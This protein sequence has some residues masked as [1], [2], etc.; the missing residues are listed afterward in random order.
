MT[1]ELNHS[2][3]ALPEH[4]ALKRK[5]GGDVEVWNDFVTGEHPHITLVVPTNENWEA[6]YLTPNEARAVAA[7]LM[8]AADNQDARASSADRSHQ[9][10]MEG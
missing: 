2:R 5:G 9:M 1:R 10:K 3:V 6:V 4:T 8:A 7:L